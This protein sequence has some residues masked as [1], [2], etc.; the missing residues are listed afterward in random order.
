MVVASAWRGR[1]RVRS[2]PE[3]SARPGLAAPAP[4]AA[5]VI[6]AALLTALLIGGACARAASPEDEHVRRVAEASPAPTRSLSKLV[7]ALQAERADAGAELIGFEE[8]LGVPYDSTQARRETD[9]ALADFT[10]VLAENDEMAAAYRLAVDALAELDELRGEVDAHEGPRDVS[11][12]DAMNRIALRYGVPVTALLEAHAEVAD[13]ID[14][15]GLRRTARLIGVCL[16]QIEIAQVLTTD[17]LLAVLSDG[18]VNDPDEIAALARRGG[19]MADGG[20]EAVTLAGI[21][22][23]DAAGELEGALEAVGLSEV[24]GEAIETGQVDLVSL[25][26]ASAEELDAWHRFLDRLLAAL[27]A[28]P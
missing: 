8:A 16:Q 21:E 10:A 1:A 11:N 19:Q 5:R 9:A 22:H 15:P 7:L 27:P 2:R 25:M 24:I 17:L 6:S 23:A 20:V 12:V 28:G 13:A 3:L 4:A 18:G 26:D 14:D